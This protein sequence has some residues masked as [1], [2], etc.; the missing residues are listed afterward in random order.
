VPLHYDT[1]LRFLFPLAALTAS[2]TVTVQDS[3]GPLASPTGDAHLPAQAG[4]CDPLAQTTTLELSAIAFR[5]LAASA[6]VI[7]AAAQVAA[8]AGAYSHLPSAA[9][10]GA[11]AAG[12]QPI[13]ASDAA[14]AAVS[15]SYSADVITLTWQTPFLPGEIRAVNLQYTVVEPNSGMTFGPVT[16]TLAPKPART[17]TPER[18]AAAAA[19]AAALPSGTTLRAQL[20]ALLAS[21]AAL[22][23]YATTAYPGEEDGTWLPSSWAGTDHESERCRHW[24]PVVDRTMAVRSRYD[25]Y[26]SAYEGMD[27]IA[28][29]IQVSQRYEDDAA[30]KEAVP[31]PASEATAT[32][33]RPGSEAAPASAAL[34]YPAPNA[35]D[36]PAALQAFA[37]ALL[38][39]RRVVTHYKLS[40]PTPPYLLALGV[41]FLAKHRAGRF[42][43]RVSPADQRAALAAGTRAGPHN[44]A[45]AELDAA[46]E[47]PQMG[48]VVYYGV[49]TD[50]PEGATPGKLARTFR[51]TIPMLH[52]IQTRLGVAF[53][54]PKYYQWV[55]HATSGA[56]E[57]VSLVTWNEVFLMDRKDALESQTFTSIVNI[58]EMAH[59]YFGDAVTS[60]HF[61]HA[62]LKESWATYM[63]YAWLRDC[64]GT[65]EMLYMMDID[66]ESYFNEASNRYVRPVSTNVYDH[67][68]SMFDSHLYPGGAWRIHMLRA[69]LG[70]AVFWD[71]VRRYLTAHMS[72]GDDAAY[73]PTPAAATAVH[74]APP[75]ES[76]DFRAALER[77]AAAA[78]TVDAAPSATGVAGAEPADPHFRVG[79][80][81][82]GFFN[83]WIYGL[84][85]PSVS[86]VYSYDTDA[87]VAA[88]ALTQTQ[89]FKATGTRTGAAFDITLP[90]AFEV[91]PGEWEVVNARFNLATGTARA[92]VAAPH[93]APLQVLVDPQR[94][95][96]AR[97]SFTPPLEM[98]LR[99]VECIPDYKAL[100]GAAAAAAS[101]RGSDAPTAMA[102]P[103]GRW[104]S[105]TG[106]TN[107]TVS[108][109]PE[110]AVPFTNGVVRAWAYQTMI[111]SY[112]Q[113]GA[114]RDRPVAKHTAAAAAAN[115]LVPGQ[116]VRRGWVWE[117]V[118]ET[119]FS[120]LATRLTADPV[121]SVRVAVAPVIASSLPAT[122]GRG[123]VAPD[124]AARYPAV[125]AAVARGA[126]AASATTLLL[127]LASVAVAG[128][129]ANPEDWTAPE[130]GARRRWYG[131][132][133][134]ASGVVS[135]CGQLKC[136]RMLAGLQT[137]LSA[138]AE[139]PP[140]DSDGDVSCVETDDEDTAPAAG[141][142]KNAAAIREF[143]TPL[144]Q[145]RL[146]YACHGSLLQA[147][148][149]QA[150]LA[151]AEATL[152]PALA[153]PTYQ[154]N[155]QRSALFAIGSLFGSDAFAATGSAPAPIEA[156][157]RLVNAAIAAYDAPVVATRAPARTGDDTVAYGNVATNN[158]RSGALSALSSAYAG[159]TAHNFPSGAAGVVSTTASLAADGV[160]TP[161][162][163]AIR[164]FFLRV[165]FAPR[166]NRALT[167]A[168]ATTAARTLGADS[169][170][171]SA[172]R[173]LVPWLPAQ[174]QLAVN[175]ALEQAAEKEKKRVE[176]LAKV[177][178]FSK[179]VTDIAKSVAAQEIA[180]FQQQ[181]T[182]KT[183][184]AATAAAAGKK[185][186]DAGEE[187]RRHRRS[188]RGGSRVFG[189]AA[190]AVVGGLM[191]LAGYF[192]GARRANRS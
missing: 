183:E 146:P 181:Q 158:I 139:A 41:G 121:P 127:A 177:R 115:A 14:A 138:G 112:A 161:L 24:L 171:A 190:L 159:L 95:V 133:D 156:A 65:E 98:L 6:A 10:A 55:S 53:P 182:E 168:V 67:S 191:V 58:H 169:E 157:A 119:V 143:V 141:R 64:Y 12:A 87:G 185:V 88:V 120:C 89:D 140:G 123:D 71:G 184:K 78:A 118:S 20:E 45:S 26:L 36:R 38:A 48:E 174:Q 40:F 97:V 110:I 11:A 42:A 103:E 124:W 165:L 49:P 101:A 178:E 66:R 176:K 69:Q 35:A 37:A 151:A 54:F 73:A 145:N 148:G 70:D 91:A 3:R 149:Q 129:A 80:N 152:V 172:V 114:T 122:V 59:S 111:K 188:S 147:I 31:A 63:E 82:A 27:A 92:A 28:N 117:T 132:Y 51:H 160:Y 136:P 153:V 173:A 47:N 79:S 85:F 135:A 130:D 44:A 104:A 81:L 187:E 15:V 109:L 9:A 93:G 100:Y 32:A 137:L 33:G 189:S 21:P 179:E 96:L 4:L 106:V 167:F 72:R 52:W 17:N 23:A 186:S 180:K 77:A 116:F 46:D 30:G 94:R 142:G 150:N 22:S 108:N 34:A 60:R 131:G 84:G 61:D 5:D 163:A 134:H 19:A 75:A 62:W 57:N 50:G 192:V 18:A 144:S 90:V 13:A 113:H 1:H 107:G 68:W 125:A 155:V 175:T 128:P 25:F 56:M 162:L 86:A 76:D 99:T 166:S 102:R 164:G 105:R 154:G 29:G 2:V 83:E 8:P 74:I 170:V 39:R 43:R 7:P 126:P 16:Q